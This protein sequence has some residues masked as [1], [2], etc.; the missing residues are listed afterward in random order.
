[1][2]IAHKRHGV[3]SMT[4]PKKAKDRSYEEF[5]DEF[6]E[7][8]VDEATKRSKDEDSQTIKS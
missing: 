2:F 6:I 1:M 7:W 4:A 8:W 5:I 3:L